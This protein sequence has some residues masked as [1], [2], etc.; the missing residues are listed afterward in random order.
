MSLTS[1]DVSPLNTSNVQEFANMFYQCVN[2]QSLD[3]STFDTRNA[4][5]M[6]G[7]FGE[8]KKL[9]SLNLNNFI[10]DVPHHD[11]LSA[12]SVLKYRKNSRLRLGVFS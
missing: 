4:V 6:G 1:L 9:P 8:C 5:Y 7:M 11:I 10:A 12:I 3:V 2:L